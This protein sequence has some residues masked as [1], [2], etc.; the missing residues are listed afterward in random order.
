LAKCLFTTKYWNYGTHEQVEWSCDS[1]DEDF[2]SRPDKCIFHDE[3]YLQL[4]TGRFLEEK[5]VRTRVMDKVRKSIVDN[6]SLFLIGYYLPDVTIRGNFTKRA[7]FKECRFLG[8]ADF[9]SAEFS[10][11]AG[12]GLAKFS[13]GADFGLAK[14]SGGADFAS[15]EFSGVAYFRSAK[16]YLGRDI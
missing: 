5:N 16:L 12:F 7:Y 9:T 2:Q 3:D 6:E 10:G 15:A 11:G 13:G 14:F 8:R 4:G 1:K